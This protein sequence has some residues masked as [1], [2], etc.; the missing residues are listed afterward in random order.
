MGQPPRSNFSL[1][2]CLLER[3]DSLSLHMTARPY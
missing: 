2:S 1:S 3:E